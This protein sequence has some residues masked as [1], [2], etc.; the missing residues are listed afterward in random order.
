MAFL[1][2]RQMAMVLENRQLGFEVKRNF[3]LASVTLELTN[4]LE[5]A[6]P[7]NRRVITFGAW[8]GE[9]S[10]KQFARKRH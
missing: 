2:L 6:S 1:Q 9:S 8:I 4:H 5:P 10:K 7:F 3:A